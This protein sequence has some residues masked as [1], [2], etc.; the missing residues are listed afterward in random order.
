MA[1]EMFG[2]ICYGEKRMMDSLHMLG[3]RDILQ[4]WKVGL[5]CSVKCPGAIVLETYDLCQRLRA[6]GVTVM[7]GFHAPMEQECMRILLSSPH[8]HIWC[9]ARGLLQRLPDKLADSQRAVDEG[10]LLVVSPF[11]ATVKRITREQAR[12]RNRLVAEMSDVLVV[13]YAAPSSS[14]EALSRETLAAGGAVFTVE[15]AA[16]ADLLALGAAP[17]A[18]LPLS[19]A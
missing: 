13:P 18:Q 3:N 19:A 12:V 10:R 7:S 6:E 15:H 1:E 17:L 2:I 8:P 4:R 11:A 14:M 5:L 16:N 9:L